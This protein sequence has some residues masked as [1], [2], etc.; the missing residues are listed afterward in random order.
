MSIPFCRV[1]WRTACAVTPSPT[2]R[3]RAH[4]L[5][6]E[7]RLR[8]ISTHRLLT[9][10]ED[11]AMDVGVSSNLRRRASK[12]TVDCPLLDIPSRQRMDSP[13]MQHDLTS[14]CFT[15]VWLCT[16][17]FLSLCTVAH[18]ENS[19]QGTLRSPRER[20]YQE[21]SFPYRS[22]IF[23]GEFRSGARGWTTHVSLSVL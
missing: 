22:F 15:S 20:F 13:G 21:C 12:S 11:A 8:S 9:M 23:V 6:G 4:G 14:I 3:M 5:P 10:S 19:L 17:R 1:I 2:R 18:Q 7:H 16:V